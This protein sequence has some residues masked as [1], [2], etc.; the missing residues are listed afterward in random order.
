MAISRDTYVVSMLVVATLATLGGYWLGSSYHQVELKGVEITEPAVLP[1]QH[2]E[3]AQ[4]MRIVGLQSSAV[5][6]D[7]KNHLSS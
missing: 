3:A 6:G 5:P 7:W 4:D 1:N 2:F